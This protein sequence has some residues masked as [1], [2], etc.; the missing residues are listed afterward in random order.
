M[1]SETT[2]DRL[3]RELPAPGEDCIH[4]EIDYTDRPRVETGDT[5]QTWL[6]GDPVIKGSAWCWSHGQWERKEKDSG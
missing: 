2:T 6:P 1:I 5:V 4:E 3:N